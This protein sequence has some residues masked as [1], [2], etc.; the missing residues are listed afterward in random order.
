[1]SQLKSLDLPESGSAT[2]SHASGNSA[3]TARWWIWLLVIAIA[4]GGFWWYRSSRA[5]SADAAVPGAAAGGGKGKGP[6]AGAYAVPVVVATA[7]SGELPVFYNGLGSVTPVATVTVRSR[8]DGQLI[9]VAFKEGQFVKQGDLLAEIDPRPFQVQLEQA[10][11]QLA[12]DQ[13]ARRDAEVNFERFKLLFKEGVIPQQQL[14]TQQSQVGQFDGAIKSDQ[15]QIDNAKLQLTYCRITSPVSGRV[16][17][18]LVDPGNI[19]HATDASG[20]VVITQIQPI[21]VVFSLPQDQLPQVYD[22]LRKGVQLNVDAFDRDNVKKITSGK[23]LTIDN[24]I[25]PTTGTYK[26]K[27]L[28][29]NADNA[30]FPNQ[31][32]NVHLLV[33]TKKGLTLVPVPAI[34]RGPQGTYVY[35]VGQGNTVNIRAVTVAQTTGNTAGVSSGLKAGDVVVT[36]GQDKL[37]EGSK[38]VPN[39]SNTGDA[40]PNASGQADSSGQPLQQNQQPQGK[41]GHQGGKKQ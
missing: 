35:A 39:T 17:L 19:I 21:S 29:D 13:A 2:G 1:M 15:A 12:K 18:R 8:V 33:D 30:L 14:D 10:E 41:T 9:N 25:D 11:G 36:D 37:Q 5:K 24:Q 20:L 32:V 26:L 6:G 28:F 7:Q 23:L 27:S 16:G 38:V 34:Q 3:S 40:Q 4:A 22:K 31:F